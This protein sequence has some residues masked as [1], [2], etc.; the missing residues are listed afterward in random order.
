MPR[1]K[2]VLA[3]VVT[4]HGF[5]TPAQAGTGHDHGPKH[6]GVAREVKNVTCELVARPDIMTLYVSDHGKLIATEG[7]KGEATIDAGNEK[8][9]VPLQPE[10]IAWPPRA[11]SGA[12]SVCGSWS[13]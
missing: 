13:P 4:A 1:N 7:A 10:K 5:G 6:G 11:F 12:G 2:L 9:R 3:S 8:T